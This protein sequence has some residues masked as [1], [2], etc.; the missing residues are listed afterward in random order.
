MPIEIINDKA[1]WDKFIDESPHGSLFLKWDFLKIIEK[2]SKTS[3]RTYGIYKGRKLVCVLPLY[4][5]KIFGMT[6]V[7]SPPPSTGVR[8]L[9]FAMAPIYKDMKQHKKESYNNLV[10]EELN[11]EMKKINP[12][13]LSISAAEGFMDMRPF[14]WSGY[15]IALE[16]TYVIDLRKSLDE[17]WKGFGKDSREGIISLSRMD[18][19]I[20]KVDNV[21]NY[22][23]LM[24][25][26]YRE[27]H[28]NFPLLEQAYMIDVLSTFPDNVGIHM[29]KKNGT[30]VDVEV[31]CAY[32]DRY[33]L[34]QGGAT[35]EKGS[36]GNQEY[37]TWE[38]IKM[39]KKDGYKTFEIMG[40]NMRRLCMFQSKFNPELELYFTVYRRDYRGKIAEWVYL[41]LI[42]RQ[43]W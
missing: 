36:H 6:M 3:L 16:Y 10:V 39:A 27:Q 40:A 22:Y 14:R 26:R 5:Q 33:R 24:E 31:S 42:K 19:K 8:N 43:M 9:G 35:I 4:I 32:G 23:H 28:L 20:E 13:Y 29:L 7:F 15:D 34:W 37:S 17:I 12:I 18:L 21:D 41:N 2:H 30:I 1:V 11:S 38:L 25:E